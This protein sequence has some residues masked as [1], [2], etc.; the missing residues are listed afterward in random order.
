MVDLFENFIGLDGFEFLEFIVLKKGMLEFIF[1]VM[2]FIF[3]VCYKL[4]DV[5]LWC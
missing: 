5:E 1:E 3:V 2:G 4:K